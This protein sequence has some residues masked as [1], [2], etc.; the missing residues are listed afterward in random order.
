MWSNFMDY[1]NTNNIEN[2][3]VSF[4]AEMDQTYLDSQKYFTRGCYGIDKVGRP[5]QVDRMGSIQIEELLRDVDEE[6]MA[7]SYYF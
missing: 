6:K 3:V 2:I 5:L 4:K 7:R 1:R